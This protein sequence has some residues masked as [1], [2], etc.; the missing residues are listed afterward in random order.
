MDDN[1]ENFLQ[2][3]NN[4]MP[5]RYSYSEIKRITEGFKVILGQGGYGSVFKGKL[6]SGRL[7]AIKMLDKSEA[8]GEDFI[9]EVA[10]IGG[11]HHINVVQL[12]GFC[13]ERSKQALVYDSMVNGS[14]DKVISSEE[15]CAF[16]LEK[17]V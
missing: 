12:I 2:A 5:I 8:N 16:K 11:I 1:T 13:V 14:L 3:Q 17:T 7:V 9:N 4:L 10:T 6:R 15:N